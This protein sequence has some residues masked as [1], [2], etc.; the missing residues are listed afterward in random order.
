MANF[1][2]FV[3]NSRLTENFYAVVLSFMSIY[4]SATSIS[5]GFWRI[6]VSLIKLNTAVKKDA[7]NR[8][9]FYRQLQM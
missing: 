5:E 7:D 2:E 8:A 1:I 3:T 4:A 6:L 9:E